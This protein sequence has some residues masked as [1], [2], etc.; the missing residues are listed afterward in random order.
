MCT[1]TGNGK[2]FPADKFMSFVMNF[3][4]VMFEK[5]FKNVHDVYIKFLRFMLGS[6]YI[7]IVRFLI[8]LSDSAKPTDSDFH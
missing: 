4:S 7:L 3:S 5:L 2:S 1:S 8:F 6:P